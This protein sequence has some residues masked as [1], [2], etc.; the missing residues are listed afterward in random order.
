MNSWLENCQR[1][2]C[3]STRAPNVSPPRAERHRT[4]R[5]AHQSTASASR[6][7]KSFN[8]TARD[9]V[10][11]IFHAHCTIKIFS[12]DSH[13]VLTPFDT[14]AIFEYSPP[15]LV[16]RVR[17]L[18]AFSLCRFLQDSFVKRL[19]VA[20][21]YYVSDVRRFLFSPYRRQPSFACSR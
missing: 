8:R 6:M 20:S 19:C 12:Y 10:T 9:V 13:V 21:Q 3:K 16:V 17:M 14:R 18:V 11:R 5:F 2:N 4:A 1:V 15:R 7:S